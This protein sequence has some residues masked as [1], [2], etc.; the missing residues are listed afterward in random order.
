MKTHTRGRNDIKTIMR[1]NVS[2][3]SDNMWVR[4]LS[5]I[6]ISSFLLMLMAVITFLVA[7]EQGSG[8]SLR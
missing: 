5:F 3:R 6:L 7:P 8:V 2:L 1:S 4:V